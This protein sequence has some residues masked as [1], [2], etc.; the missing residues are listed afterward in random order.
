MGSL[1]FSI[2][3]KAPK[4]KVWNTMLQQETYRIW[5]AEFGAGSYFEGS[6]EQGKRIRFLGSDG[7]AGVTSVIAES[8]PYCYISIKHLGVI[9]AGID[10]TESPEAKTWASA[11]ENY[12]FSER[13]DRTELK[14]ELSGIPMEFKQY[15]TDTWPKALARLKSLCK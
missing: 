12:T 2:T 3:I 14:V 6:W 5:T 7:S 11:Y 4:E 8:Q 13:A 10:D 9:T 1:N 15:M